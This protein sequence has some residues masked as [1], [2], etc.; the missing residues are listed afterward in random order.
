MRGPCRFARQ[1][2]AYAFL[3]SRLRRWLGGQV[4]QGPLPRYASGFVYLGLDVSTAL[5][6]RHQGEGAVQPLRGSGSGN[7]LSEMPI[8]QKEKIRMTGIRRKIIIIFLLIGLVPLFSASM[9]S[10]FSSQ[11]ALKQ[12][13]G[14]SQRDLAIEVMDKIDKE[15][16]YVFVLARNWVN[17]PQ[18][19]HV[20][21]AAKQQAPEALLAEWQKNELTE[22]AT[23]VLLKQLRSTTQDR[24]REIFV[25]DSRGYVIAAT[26][27]TSDFD[28]GPSDDPPAG[29]PWWAAAVANA[30][31][32][33]EVD[34]DESAGVYAVDIAVRIVSNGE[35]IG[36]LKA[37]Y[38][39]EKIQHFVDAASKGE[40]WRYELVNRDGLIIATR[41]EERDSIL[42]EGS[43]VI[44]SG[45][46]HK[47]LSGESGFT[48]GIDP[49]GSEVLVG[50]AQTR[51][52]EFG[53][54]AWMV[55]SYIPV[56][57][58]YLL[59]R[60]QVQGFVLVSCLAVAVILVVSFTLANRVVSE[61][62]HKELLAQELAVEK[63]RA[64]VM[65]M[66]HSDDMVQVIA[67]V[68]K[69]MIELGLNP[70][71][72]I[73]SFIDVETESVVQF[74]SFPNPRQRGISWTSPDLV[75]IDEQ[76]A[77]GKYRVEENVKQFLT[78]DWIERWRNGRIWV[79]CRSTEEIAQNTQLLSAYFGIQPAP[80]KAPEG[81]SQPGQLHGEQGVFTNV[82]FTHGVLAVSGGELT[83]NEMKIVEE[84]TEALS[85]GYLRFLDIQR[86]EEQNIQI[87]EATRHKSEFLARMS[88]D[89]RT[90]MNAIIGFTR[91]LLRRAKDV[92]DKR[93]FRN[94]D[95]IRISANNLLSL[96]NDILDLSKIEAGHIDINP[97]DVDLKQLATEC[98]I[99][100]ESL[101][102]PGVQLEQQ[103][104]DLNPVHTDADCIRRVVMNLLGNALKF[105][106]QG[107]I[108]IS[109]KPVNGWMEFSVADTGS[110]I[111]P[112]DLPH[113]FDEFRQ[114]DSQEGAKQEG[115]GLGLSIAKRSVE[116][117]GGTISVESEVGKGTKFSLRIKDYEKKDAEGAW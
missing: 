38:N 49:H 72:A 111:P 33:G 108:T 37:V 86:L 54:P 74:Y 103:L 2:G 45:A 10:F 32:W 27:R 89:L 116:L 97:E 83:E 23:A 31:H 71:A 60:E 101:V 96:I 115:T 24:F 85:L 76:V 39:M 41:A 9:L 94:L 56:D 16:N 58:A 99:S 105:T 1:D 70:S 95:N 3:A 87:Q 91:I 75:E 100:I 36:V 59:L 61:L 50:Y 22:N 73:I 40:T 84:L 53:H 29:E 102:K 110:G 4:I 47:T 25:T 117:L 93:Q 78:A 55:L 104:E 42:K 65:S 90:P 7:R 68:Y 13:I 26:N 18:I 88:H 21:T 12:A 80:E 64:E 79:S 67:L 48:T 113:I 43:T 82:S 35:V 44:I 107:R 14:S 106:E 5:A 77:V 62:G 98:A 46:D 57:E 69:S 20:A 81:R 52:R 6:D 114:V 34:Y 66:R 11:N 63:V 15:M 19:V 8:R 109:L 51:G 30:E 92:L 112:E 28:Q 17:I